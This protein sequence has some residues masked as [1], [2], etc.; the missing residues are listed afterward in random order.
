MFRVCTLVVVGFVAIGALAAAP[1]KAVPFQPIF[2]VADFVPNAPVDNPYFPLKPGTKFVY[3]AVFQEDGE[4]VVE[5]SE[6]IV[7][8]NRRT[9]AGVPSVVVRVTEFE[10]DEKTE[11][12]EDYYAQD[13]SGNVWYMGEASVTLPDLDPAG[14]WIALENGALPGWIMPADPNLVVG[15]NY[16]QE[17][18]PAD[19]AL[20][21]ATVLARD[22]VVSIPF[23][24]FSDV[25]VTLENTV[26]E[27][28]FFETKHY[29]ADVGLVLI[30]EG[31]DSLGGG[32][33]EK[34]FT[35]QSKTVVPEP[36]TT[37]VVAFAAI[38]A[39]LVGRRYKQIP[40]LSKTAASDA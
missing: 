36:A 14:S 4:T 28:G 9:I 1:V 32:E 27:P 22:G 5:T 15:F 17:N 21:Q 29:A 33:P 6:E 39:V 3:Q 30:R 34:V 7:T 38:V 37:G 8:F 25:L 26:V 12:T 19:G 16:Y 40:T 2:N 20:D 35:L 31:T 10:G 18:A 23:G 11:L 24:D 13:N